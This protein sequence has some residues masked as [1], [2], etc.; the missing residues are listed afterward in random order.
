MLF[1]ETGLLILLVG[2]GMVVPLLMARPVTVASGYSIRGEDVI[3]RRTTCGRAL[4]ILFS[5]E[6][7]EDVR[8]STRDHCTKAARSR[9]V[10]VAFIGI[11]ALVA[12][13]IGIRNGPYRPPEPISG[14]IPPPRR[15]IWPKHPPRKPR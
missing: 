4:S 13:S 2:L 7:H 1:R 6:Y 3:E 12:A 14:A 5:S 10:G 8:A 11:V 15:A 9:L